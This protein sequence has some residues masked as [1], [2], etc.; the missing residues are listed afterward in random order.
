MRSEPPRRAVPA[1]VPAIAAVVNGWIDATPWFRRVHAP[2][3]IEGLVRDVL[4]RRV[5]WVIGAPVAGYLSLDPAENRVAALFCARTG[6]GLGKAL[7]DVAKEG[8]TFL[9]LR[10][11]VPNLAA[12]RFYRREGFVETGRADP[13]PPETVP[14]VVMEWRA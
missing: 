12:Q 8:R 10:T 13:E 2:E 9:T 7:M 11:H 6:E 1:D 4:P 14:E 5:I 3:T